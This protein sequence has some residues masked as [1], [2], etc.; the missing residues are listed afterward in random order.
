MRA[1]SGYITRARGYAGYVKTKKGTELSFSVLFNN[2][3]CSPSEAKHKIEKLLEA[4][5]EL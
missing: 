4:L 3:N 5:V 1:K 2:Y